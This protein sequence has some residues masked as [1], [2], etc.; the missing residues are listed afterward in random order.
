[1]AAYRLKRNHRDA[2]AICDPP[3]L[4]AAVL[5]ELR[6]IIPIKVAV[7]AGGKR[8][9]LSAPVA[10]VIGCAQRSVLAA[11]DARRNVHEHIH[12]GGRGAAGTEVDGDSFDHDVFKIVTV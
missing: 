7:V 5:T 11:P 2:G 1:L 10:K 12:S 9:I 3:Q 8:G 6:G 4:P